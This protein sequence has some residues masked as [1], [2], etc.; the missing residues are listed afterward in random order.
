MSDMYLF[1]MDF[2]VTN[3]A[4]TEERLDKAVAKGYITADEE[5]TILATPR[6]I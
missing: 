5:K 6:K 2:W 3:P 1:F 4:C